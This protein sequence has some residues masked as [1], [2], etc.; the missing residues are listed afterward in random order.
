VNG[1]APKIAQKIGV[2]LQ[3]NDV[4]AGARQQKAQHHSR[5]PA[6]GNSATRGN[7]LHWQNLGVATPKHKAQADIHHHSSLAHPNHFDDTIYSYTITDGSCR[8]SKQQQTE[9]GLTDQNGI[10]R[11]R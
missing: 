10:K 7:G 4:D 8:I 5:R 2:F 1:V 9:F 11:T 3:N 6:A